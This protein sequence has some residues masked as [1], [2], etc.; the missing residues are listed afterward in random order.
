MASECMEKNGKCIS[1]KSFIETNAYLLK[2]S[3]FLASYYTSIY[4]Q[5][6]IFSTRFAQDYG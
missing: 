1:Q 2:T 6:F 5:F 4:L 3:L